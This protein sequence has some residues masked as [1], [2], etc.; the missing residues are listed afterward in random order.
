LTPSH[1]LLFNPSRAYYLPPCL[2]LPFIL[3][4]FIPHD[5]FNLH[6]PKLCRTCL[7]SAVDIFLDRFT[8]P[9][10]I[11]C[12]VKNTTFT[13][14]RLYFVVHWCHAVEQLSINKAWCG[15]VMILLLMA[16]INTKYT[17]YQHTAVEMFLFLTMQ[18]NGGR[19]SVD[20]KVYCI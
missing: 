15:G 16:T 3:L 20:L 19:M 18:N 2:C 17:S 10:L 1:L 4:C 8:I 14:A 7:Q 12:L 11:S 13:S 9:T 5:P 6:L